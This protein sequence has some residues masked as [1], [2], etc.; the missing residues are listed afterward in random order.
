MDSTG[1]HGLIGASLLAAAL[2]LGCSNNPGGAPGGN[3]PGGKP[4]DP[5]T[6]AKEPI[7][8]NIIASGHTKMNHVH[9]KIEITFENLSEPWLLRKPTD[10]GSDS[11][12]VGFRKS[13]DRGEFTLHPEGKGGPAIKVEYLIDDTI[14]PGHGGIYVDL[15]DDRFEISG[16]PVIAARKEKLVVKREGR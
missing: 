11:K 12:L 14:K 10:L 1:H 15:W 16:E 6:A 3:A 7:E 2:C 13:G 8:V 5:P 9:D 4:G